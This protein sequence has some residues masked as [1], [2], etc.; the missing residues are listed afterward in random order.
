MYIKL[1][2]CC[3]LHIKQV[4]S[5]HYEYY[6]KKD[7]LQCLMGLYNFAV[8][9]YVYDCPQRQNNCPDCSHEAKTP[10]T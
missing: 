1:L 10:C 9:E 6:F 3:S 4:C 2:Q 7:I 5:L 8:S